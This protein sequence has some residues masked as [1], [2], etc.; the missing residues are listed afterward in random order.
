M[1]CEHLNGEPGS[2]HIDTP[3]FEACH[4]CEEFL[5]VDRVVQFSTR[6]FSG[7][8][9]DWMQIGLRGGLGQDATECVVGGAGFD[10]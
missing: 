6:K 10:G 3:L 7:V 1:I 5:V 4:H 9:T 2:F 8:V